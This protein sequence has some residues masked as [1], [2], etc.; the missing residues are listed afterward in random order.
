MGSTYAA[1]QKLRTSTFVSMQL[2]QPEVPLLEGEHVRF[3]NWAN[4]QLSPF[5]DS[6]GG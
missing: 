4:E 2:S 1:S 5:L 3:L 6:Y